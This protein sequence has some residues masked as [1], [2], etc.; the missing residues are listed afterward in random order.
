MLFRD[1]I[2]S[3]YTGTYDSVGRPQYTQVSY[4][5]DTDT[6]LFD[7]TSTL[8]NFIGINEPVYAEPINRC[9]KNVYDLQGKLLDMCKEKYTN[10]YPYPTQVVEVS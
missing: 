6:S 5:T 8:D 1:N 10:K 2:H 4:I 7:Y 9:L 3:K